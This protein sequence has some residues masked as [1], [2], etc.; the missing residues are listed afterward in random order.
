C[1][2]SMSQQNELVELKQLIPNLRYDL[3][4]A[5][6]NNFTG[7]RIYPKNTQSTYLVK[8]AAASLKNIAME[9]QAMQLGILLWDA[10]RPYRAT[11]KFWNLIHDERYVA[12]PAK[13]SGHNRGIAVDLT[14]FDLRTGQLLEMPTGFDNFSDTA[15]HCFMLLNAE[16]IKNR[17]LLKNIMEKHGFTSFATEWWHYAWPNDRD[18]KMLNTSF[19][20]LKK[21]MDGITK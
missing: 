10:Y 20:K 15:H 7:K 21:I 8:E 6:N 2:V 3:K 19:K 5:S 1:I 9:L 16:K 11:V 12:N 17:M 14:L 18:Y 13:G 4:Y